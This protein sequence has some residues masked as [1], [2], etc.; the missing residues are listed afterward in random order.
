MFCLSAISRHTGAQLLSFR[1]LDSRPRGCGFEPHRRHCVVSLS[2]N[3]N[4]S[5]VLVQPRRTHLFIT[6]RLL[7]GH[8][9]SNQTSKISGY[10]CMKCFGFEPHRRHCVV[11]LSKNINPSLVLVQP[12][13]ARLFITKRLLMGH[14]E[15]NQTSKI[16]GYACMKCFGFQPHR[17]HC[18]VSLSKNINPSLVLVQPRRTR[19]FITKR[20]LMG[21]KESNQTNKISGYAWMKCFGFEPHRRHCVVSLSK[22]INPSLVLVQPRRTRLFITKRL[23]MGHKESNQTNKISGHTCM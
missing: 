13:R 7:M 14:K 19:L 17:R 4:P 12:R 3:I 18:V 1:V 6:K 10:A 11:S 21:H 9:E 15:S 16:S 23:L 5:L 22:N 8:K 20:L 2:T